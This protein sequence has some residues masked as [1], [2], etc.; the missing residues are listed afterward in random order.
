MLKRDNCKNCVSRCEH[1]GKDREFVCR[2]GKSCKVSPSP[3]NNL[4]AAIRFC[5]AIR[6]LA[7]KPENL[8]NLESYLTSHFAEWLKK[9]ANTPDAISTELKSFAEMEF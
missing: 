4:E 3:D 1:A 5:E 6:T 7:D 8:S 2:G 9:W